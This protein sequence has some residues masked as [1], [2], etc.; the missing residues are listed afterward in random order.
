[1]NVEIQKYTS[2]VKSEVCLFNHCFVYFSGVV[3]C[4]SF[5]V[6]I[7]AACQHVHRD[8][9]GSPAAADDNR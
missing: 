3:S 4:L 8:M 7:K 6:L 2:E 1:M 9:I 5:I